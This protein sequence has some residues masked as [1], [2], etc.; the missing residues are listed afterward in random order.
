MKELVGYITLGYPDR[1]KSTKACEVLLS[2]GCDMLELGI[3]FSDPLADGPVIKRAST[4]SIERG[5]KVKQAF[6]I[7]KSLSKFKKP[8]IFLSYLNPILKFGPREF[9]K[10]AKDSGVSALIIPD[11]PPE[12]GFDALAQEYGIDIIYMLAPTST[13]ERIKLVSEKT[14]RFIYLVSVTGVTGMRE[15]L[16]EELEEVIAKVKNYSDKP[17][18]VGF[19]VSSVEEAIRV[20]KIADGVIIGSKLISLVDDDPSLKKLENF[21]REIKRRKEVEV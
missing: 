9:F 7:A 18:F 19:G 6:E 10:R 4:I 8:L 12:D 16:P 11:L 21:V 15:R 13:D 1:D 5:F 3:P 17:V 14:K 2:S 20:L